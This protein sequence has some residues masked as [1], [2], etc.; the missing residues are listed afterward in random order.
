M[1]DL[2]IIPPA[3]SAWDRAIE[4]VTQQLEAGEIQPSD[5]KQHLLEEINRS[6]LDIFYRSIIIA[7]FIGIITGVFLSSLFGA[8]GPICRTNYVIF[9]IVSCIVLIGLV[10]Y[11]VILLRTLKSPAT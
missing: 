3:G 5:I 7:P 8:L 10:A 2:S 1:V 11:F 4:R 6:S 9:T